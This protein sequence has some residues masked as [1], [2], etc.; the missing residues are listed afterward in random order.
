MSEYI[1][2]SEPVFRGNEWTY[3]RECLDTGWVSTA[4]SFVERFEREISS[5]TGARHA[6]ACMNGTSALHISLLLAGISA[7]DEV[8][9]ST[10]TFIAPVNAVRYC[11]AW[12]VFMDADRFYN[13]DCG[14]VAHFLDNETVYRRGQTLNKRTGRRI[15]AVIPVHVFGNAADLSELAALC[16]DRNIRII[17]DATESL[18]TVYSGGEYDGRHTGTI[19][20]T[21]CLSFNGNKIITTGGGGMLL[22]DDPLL[23]ERARYLTTQ[24]KDDP[25]RYVHNETGY[26]YRMTNLQAAV[27][28]A[29]LERLGEILEAKKRIYERYR[30]GLDPLTGVTLAAVPEYAENN[31]WMCAVQIKGDEFGESPGELMERFRRRKIQVRPVW[32]LNHLQK[33]YSGCQSHLIE[34]AYGLVDATLNVPSGGGLS[35]ADIEAVIGVFKNE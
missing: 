9:I 6:V 29:Q 26:N 32:R 33:P 1:P 2:L 24:A 20:G 8:L 30:E 14:K 21:G 34:N 11:G 3:V 28:V 7:G 27:G 16:D 31:L 17:E 15:A 23:A 25:I 19:G 5:Y 12:P 18:G 22:T 35:S 4:G 10:L 13:I